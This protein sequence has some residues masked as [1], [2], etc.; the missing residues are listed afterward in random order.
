LTAT[1]GVDLCLVVVGVEEVPGVCDQGVDVAPLVSVE[2]GDSMI[3]AAGRRPANSDVAN[4]G[5][6]GGLSAAVSPSVVSPVAGGLVAV[7]AGWVR[8]AD[9]T[10]VA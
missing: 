5:S 10:A 1:D 6:G 7:R 3:I 9:L 2:P 8:R 4:D